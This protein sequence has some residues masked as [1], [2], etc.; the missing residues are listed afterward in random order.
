MKDDE[1]CSMIF[2]IFTTL[3]LFVLPAMAIVADEIETTQL[4]FFESKVRPLLAS[5]C[6]Q[7]H[8]AE[9]QKGELRLDSSPVW[10]G[11]AAAG[12]RLYLAAVD[13]H[14]VCLS[15]GK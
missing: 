2:R 12:E 8:G 11:L 6:V 10:D 13:G 3:G 9:K 5:Q 7:C 15:G 14:V 4:K 1:R